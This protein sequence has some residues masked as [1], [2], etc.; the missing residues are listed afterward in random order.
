MLTESLVLLGPA[1][2]WPPAIWPASTYSQVR[3]A[4]LALS[5]ITSCVESILIVPINTASK[6]SRY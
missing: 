2:T 6:G 4:S 1:H 3:I 5:A